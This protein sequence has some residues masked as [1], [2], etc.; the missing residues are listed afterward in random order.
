[1]AHP[2]Y[3]L[4]ERPLIDQ[5]V[6]MGWEYLQG[7]R[8]GAPATRAGDSERDSFA[9]VVHEGRFFAAVSRL[10]P[11]PE[12]QPWLTDAQ[13]R[14]ILDRL[15]GRGPGQGPQADRGVA[16]NLEVTRM[17]REGVNARTLPGWTKGLPEHVR[18]VDWEQP[19]RHD[20]DDPRG[21]DLLA[22]SQ[23][24]VEREKQQG[25]EGRKSATPDLV[26][27]V[28]GLPWV[29]I[30]CKAPADRLASH[31]SVDV[32]SR[33]SLDLA[34]G[35]VIGYAGVDEAGSIPEFVRFAQVLVATDG[36]HAELGTV[37]S[38]PQ[39]FAPWR[40]V[41]PAREDQV[42]E[43]VGAP[44]ERQL[45][46]Q[47]TLVAGVLRPAH[48]LTLV[49]DF[50]TQAGR[51]PRTVKV[52][53]R[54]QQFRAVHRIAASLRARQAARAAGR[55]TDHRGGVTWHTQGSGKSLTMAFLVRHLRSTPEL[56]GHK[57]V[58]V[59]D[60]RDLEEQIRDSLCAADER[61]YRS[62]SVKQARRFLAVDV[63]DVVLVMLQK[64]RRDDDASYDGQDEFLAKE[65][66]ER[67]HLHN[68]VANDGHDI[69]V[70]ID[71]AHRGQTAW[72]HARLRAMLPNA[73]MLGFTGTPII[74]RARKTTEDIFGPFADTYT[75]RDAERDGAVVPVRYAA[76][77]VSLEVLDKA[78]LD[79]GF[80][81]QVPVEPDR[82][83]RVLRRFG[84][85][86]EILESPAV[87]AAKAEHM[88]WHWAVTAM[89]DG[90]GAQVVAVSR[91]AAVRYQREL[92]AALKRL[93]ARI[94]GLGP[95]LH[96]PEA[97]EST[98]GEQR[99]LIR[100]ARYRNLLARIEVAAVISGDRPRDPNCWKL[101]TDKARHAE[102]IDR[103]KRGVPA[104]DPFAPP[105]ERSWQG[106]APG[107][108][109]RPAG[110]GGGPWNEGRSRSV[111]RH[112]PGEPVQE[113]P[114]GFLVV[115]SMLLTGFDA[116]PE[117]VLYL[118]RRLAGAGLLQGIARTNRPYPAKE[119]GLVVD[120]VGVGPELARSL[121]AYEEAH[122]RAVFG[123]QDVSFDHLDPDHTGPQPTRDRLWLQA[124]A[125]ADAL[126]ADRH[127]IL[128]R[129]LTELGATSLDDETQRE[130]LLARLADPL[131]RGEF[132]EIVRNF[133][134]ALGAV[135][136]RPYA[137]EYEDF[138]RRIGEVQYLVRA[139]YLDDR[140]QFSPRR[141]G[142]KV[143]DLI[144]RHLKVSG[145]EERVPPATLTAPDFLEK[146]L[147]TPD[148]RTRVSYLTSRLRTHITA[149]LDADRTRYEKFSERLQEVV[150]RMGED[151]EQAAASLETLARDVLGVEEDGGGTGATGLD[152]WTEQPV[153]GLLCRDYEEA[154]GPAVPETIDRVKAARDV[155]ACIAV[156]VRSPNFQALPEARDRVRRELRNYLEG[157]LHV[158]WAVTGPMANLLVELAAERHDDFLR[159]APG[160]EV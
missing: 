21:N 64:A 117:Q 142:A 1:M 9:E 81:E 49:R 80:D 130:D 27:F 30:E 94:D 146:V 103:F 93:V 143:R 113:A 39:H 8:P 28:N 67:D 70:L 42:R 23:F 154:D 126:L 108:A 4:V 128:T 66:G 141:Y 153:Y 116:P 68:R 136:P 132:D 7:A 119:F 73:A 78:R 31:L 127:R 38:E 2:E 3:E 96:D 50:T 139:R 134:T 5:L 99:E 48:L 118:D 52:V 82:R 157:E 131:L 13:L 11:G 129:L 135:L 72:Q 17:L 114:L 147:A 76:E 144:A 138:A 12:G 77:S 74:N 87:I 133:L 35:Q 124:D 25:T 83:L 57:V 46:A 111:G 137:L 152:P 22:V 58:V 150:R 106:T 155:A 98:S 160:D 24:R 109:P 69:V 90:F 55:D 75:L 14:H 45:T 62:R 149:R 15:T 18:L 41:E 89:R 20:E 158:D 112:R 121:A 29:V 159:Y 85:R 115:N 59:T 104:R 44:E 123:Y 33:I 63:P 32:D 110:R 92:T 61:I 19:S 145:I 40:T 84:R 122:L 34:V 97:E 140:D 56:A 125:A 65:P 16:G 101:W 71:E 47:E 36:D 43:E 95:L 79:A 6:A 148:A 120:Y 54:Y 10:N 60:R 51:G 86:K 88:V 26:L 151:F 156:L 102:Y 37:T 53:G 91:K 107:R 100:L 105:A